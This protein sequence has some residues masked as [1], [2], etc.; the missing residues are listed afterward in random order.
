MINRTVLVG[1]LTRDPELKYTGNGIPV[2]TFTLACDRPKRR[3]AEG[4]RQ[5]DFIRC[6][7]WRQSA[8]FLS[9]Y[10]SK[11]RLTGVD[12]RIQVRQYEASDGQQRT[13]VEVVANSVQL[14]DRKP[15]GT[16]AN[17]SPNTTPSEA[18]S[19]EA[20]ENGTNTFEPDDNDMPF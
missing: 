10:G 20:F 3:D 5:T 2:A 1:R 6:V 14:L 16:E 11:G 19:N 13:S 9:N 8:E 15:E 4:E 12:G 17:S 7:A 18:P